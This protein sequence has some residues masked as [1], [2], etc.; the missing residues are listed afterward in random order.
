MRTGTNAVNTT[1]TAAGQIPDTPAEVRELRL[2]KLHT[3]G[4]ACWHRPYAAGAGV[5]AQLQRSPGES[6][7]PGVPGGHPAAGLRA[8]VRAQLPGPPGPGRGRRPPHYR[9]S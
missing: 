9:A 8:A 1:R 7:A 4:D 3:G 6:A 5:A 2:G